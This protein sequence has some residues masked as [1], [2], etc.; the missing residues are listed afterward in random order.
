ME[1]AYTG[2]SLASVIG[3]RV[4]QIARKMH[5]QTRRRFEQGRA[6]TQASIAVVHAQA[7]LP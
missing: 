4:R 6:E 7:G 3:A 1:A 2:M 5:R